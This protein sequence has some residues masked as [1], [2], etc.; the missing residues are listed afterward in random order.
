MIVIASLLRCSDAGLFSGS[1][2]SSWMGSEN[3]GEMFVFVVI[4]I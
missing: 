4:I 1:V 2:H 3:A